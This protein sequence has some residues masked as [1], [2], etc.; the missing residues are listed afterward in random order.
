M[1]QSAIQTL[2]IVGAGAMGRGIVQIALAAGLKV[3]LA[4][5]RMEACEEARDFV[6][7]MLGR[8]QEKGKL[9]PSVLE[10]APSRLT[11]VGLE[12]LSAFAECDA[13]VEAIIEQVGPK[14]KLFRDL[15]QLV[16][17]DCILATNTSSLSVTEIASACHKPERVAGFHFFNPVPL[18]KIVEVIR[19][20]LTDVGVAEKLSVL[21]TTMGHHPVNVIDMPGFLVNH[22]GRGYGTEALRI[23]SEGIAG[24]EDIDR[25]LR[26][27][28]GFRMGP[29]ELL[30]LTGLDVSHRVMESI[31]QQFYQDP[32]YRPSPITAQRMTAGLLGRKTGRGF[33]RYEN[34]KPVC[35]DEPPAPT[36][37]SVHVWI[38]PE[39]EP[40][41]Q[42]LM[43]VLASGSALIETGAKPTSEAICFVTPLGQDATQSAIRQGLD[44]ARTVAVDTL[45]GLEQRRTLMLT[46]V[47]ESR[48]RD[49]A[50]GLLAEDGTAVTVIQDSPGFIAQRALAAII[51]IACEIAQLQIAVPD[52]ID[53]AVQ[54]GLGYPHG[55]MAWADQ[56]GLN[57]VMTVLENLQQATGDPRY[58]PSGWLLRRAQL[59]IS[60][61][62]T[63]ALTSG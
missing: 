27:Q 56:L 20:Q 12:K 44:P 22:A 46:P 41:C 45:F 2:G 63:G 8:L 58:R 52:D 5:A 16:S 28:C 42:Q 29:F 7:K 50:H 24:F 13:V 10:S 14:Q 47:T 62:K 55:P 57:N 18:M 19:G 61:K 6:M 60:A 17:S 25:V 3:V 21:A 30:D 4:D 26:D 53:T 11:I 43:A 23:L 31:Y 37:E 9:D 35:S 38:S 34:G 51:N 54:L 15:E 33:Y 59:G 39:H 32:R 49:L 48:V 1:S 36:A 40:G